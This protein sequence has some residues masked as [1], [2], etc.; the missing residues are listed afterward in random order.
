VLLLTFTPSDTTHFLPATATVTIDV[1]KATP[2]VTW[3]RPADIASGTALG[4]AQLDA[5]ARIPGTFAYS[6]GPGTVLPAGGGQGLS[7]VFTPSD[8]ADYNTVSVGTLINVLAPPPPPPALVTIQSVSL[9]PIKVGKIKTQAISV[10]LSGQVNAAAA[11]NLA[12][13]TLTT[14]PEGKKHTTKSVAL[15]RAIYSTDTETVTL[16]AK[17]PPLVLT[18][19][20]VLTI[21]ANNLLDTMGRAVDATGTGQPG[22]QYRAMLSKAGAIKISA[23]EPGN[24]L[25]PTAQTVDALRRGRGHARSMMGQRQP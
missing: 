5:Q 19:P 18:S 7:A 14:A 12:V 1:Q 21:N 6:P 23:V 2:V 25:H 22:G 13:Y 9:E 10:Q 4:P 24:A 3:P 15:G 8:A 16:T 20:L 11:D 17:K